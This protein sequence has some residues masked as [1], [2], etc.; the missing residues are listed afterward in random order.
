MTIRMTALKAF[1][2]A[3]RALR[4]GVEFSVKSEREARLLS[5]IGRARRGV[6]EP[7]AIPAAPKAKRQPR[8]AAPV[9]EAPKEEATDTAAAPPDVPAEPP[10]AEEVPAEESDAQQDES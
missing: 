6:E 3:H 4:P 8:K 9:I 7:V 5:A 1:S 2:Y 10:A